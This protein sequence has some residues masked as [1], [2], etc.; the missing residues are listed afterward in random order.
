MTVHLATDCPNTPP[1]DYG[2]GVRLGPVVNGFTTIVLSTKKNLVLNWNVI[3]DP[4]QT[5]NG[6]EIFT[7]SYGK[8]YL[9]VDTSHAWLG[10]R[11]QGLLPG[12]D[13]GRRQDATSL[14]DSG[15]GSPED[16]PGNIHDHTLHSHHLD[17]V[18]LPPI[19]RQAGLDTGRSGRSGRTPGTGRT[20]CATT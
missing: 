11:S 13:R 5:S 3:K 18:L 1:A 12:P 20:S 2:R 19:A 17:E 6:T 4:S 7:L 8:K 16:N 15:C 14:T 10:S 9:R